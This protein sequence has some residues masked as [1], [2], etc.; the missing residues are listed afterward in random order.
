M[1]GPVLYFLIFGIGFGGVFWFVFDYIRHLRRQLVLMQIRLVEL[2]DHN[3]ELV[4]ALEDRA[5]AARI[6]EAI[7]KGRLRGMIDGPTE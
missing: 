6:D 5:D 4:L 1:R 2:E 7:R 3:A